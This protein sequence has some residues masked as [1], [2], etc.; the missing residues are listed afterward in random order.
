MSE[1]LDHI[2]RVEKAIEKKYG[3]ET[4]INPKS[5]WSNE[6]EKSFLKDLKDF[7]KRSQ[8]AKPEKV[9]VGNVLISEAFLGESPLNVCPVCDIYSMSRRDDVYMS[10]F[11]CCMRCYF[12]YVDG[13]ET[14][15]STGWRP[16]KK[17]LNPKTA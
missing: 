13:R 10:K 12:D 17:D 3:Q 15:W 16:E 11:Q 1:D 14:R 8:L 4:I 7:Y 9:K 6:K 5:G 2:A